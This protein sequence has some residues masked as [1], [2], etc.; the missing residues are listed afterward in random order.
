VRGGNALSQRFGGIGL[1]LTTARKLMQL[2]GGRLEIA[3]QPGRGARVTLAFP[4]ARFTAPGF[5]ETGERR[6][7]PRERVG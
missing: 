4:A 3:N 5:P 6:R 7:M 2:H 1:G